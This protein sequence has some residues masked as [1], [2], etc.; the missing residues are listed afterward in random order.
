MITFEEAYAMAIGAIRKQNKT[1]KV[2]IFEAL[3]R[4]LAVDVKSDIP[5]P[6]F[7]KSAMDGYACRFAD[8]NQPMSVI[9]VVAAGT[10]PQ[11]TI[12]IGECAKIMTGAMMPAGADGVVKIEDTEEIAP[13]KVICKKTGDS[14]NICFTGEDIQPDTLLIPNGTVIQPQHIAV[15]AAVGKMEVEVFGKTSVGIISTG[16][17]LVEPNQPLTEGKIRNSN[18]YQL[19]AQALKH[20]ALPKYYGIALDD[21]KSVRQLIEKATRENQITLLSGG[22]SMGDF[23]L[24]PEVLTELGF[25]THF[26]SIAVQPGKPTLFTQKE[27]ALCFGL[28][29]NPVSSFIQFELLVSPLIHKLQ[30]EEVHLVFS[31]ATLKDDYRR[32]NAT[33]KAWIPVLLD[34]EM[35]ISQVEYHGSAHINAFVEANAIMEIPIGVPQINKGE[36]VNVRRLS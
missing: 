28:P 34:H 32:K 10:I 29:G 11:K 25:Q 24:V 4:V 20:G 30:G 18:G 1:E 3:N 2:L 22:V 7:N 12:G 36:K 35:Q 5:M 6:P 19:Y 15:L 33:R 26:Q 8:R 16:N 23:D 13:D 31:S 27:E 17:E 14:K 9:E 21:K